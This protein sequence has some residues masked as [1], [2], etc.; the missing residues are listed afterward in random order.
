MKK[1]LVAILILFLVLWL[2][3]FKL[4]LGA[5]IY[6]LWQSNHLFELKPNSLGTVSILIVVGINILSAFCSIPLAKNRRRN[7]IVWFL[8]A[9]IFN[10]WALIVLSLLH[11]SSIDK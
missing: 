4:G 2:V 5:L 9:L 11:R 3:I 6:N 10:I 1:Y 7:K 8:L